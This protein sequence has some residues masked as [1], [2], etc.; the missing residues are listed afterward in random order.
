[1]LLLS[2]VLIKRR[3]KIEGF[4]ATA[5]KTFHGLAVTSLSVGTGRPVIKYFFNN[6]K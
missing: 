6:G 1:M 5:K 2:L 4:E 3:H